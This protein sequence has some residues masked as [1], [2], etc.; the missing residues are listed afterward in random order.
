MKYRLF[1]WLLK[2]LQRRC[3]HAAM[4]ADILEGDAGPYAVKWCET[5]GAVCVVVDGR[6]RYI[7]LPEPLWESRSP[8]TR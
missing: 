7:R 2:C 8:R 1:R 5:C 4:K 6:P 3:T